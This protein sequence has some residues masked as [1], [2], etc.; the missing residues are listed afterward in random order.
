MRV[1]RQKSTPGAALF[2]VT[3]EVDVSARYPYPLIQ[4]EKSTHCSNMDVVIGIRRYQD[5]YH[6]P[7]DA[8]VTLTVQALGSAL[9]SAL[10]RK[11]FS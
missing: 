10:E 4:E 8:I 6:V 9:G 3:F 1:M 7:F 5:D 11:E 2:D